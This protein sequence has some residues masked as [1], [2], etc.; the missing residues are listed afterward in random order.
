VVFSAARH[1][2]QGLAMLEAV[3]AGA[4]P[5]VPDDLCYQEQYPPLCRYPNGDLQAA[6]DRIERYLQQPSG[7]VG[8][9]TV[10]VSEWLSP[11]VSKQWQAWLANI[12]AAVT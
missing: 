6:A 1:E 10:D 5:V 4:F 3:S 7:R 2:F 12:T 8:S 11:A 9:N